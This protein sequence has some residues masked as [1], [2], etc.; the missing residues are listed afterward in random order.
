MYIENYTSDEFKLNLSK[1]NIVIIPVGSLEAHGH[2]LPLGTDIFSPKLFCK[3]INEKLEDSI[4]IAPEI[5]YGQSYELTVYPGTINVPSET[6]SDYMYWVG[7]GF[8][9]NGI[10]KII[11]LNGHG[12]NINALNLASE[13]LI[14]LGA[15]VATINW[16]L[17][18]SSDILTITDTQGHGGE[19][20]TSA[21]LY[22]NEKL[23]HMDKAMKNN[24]KPLIKI[25]YK[26]SAKYLYKDALSG[27]ATKASKEKG[28]KIFKL[29]T[30]KIIDFIKIVD[31]GVYFISEDN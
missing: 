17:D 2:H 19:D 15:E 10:L 16:W 8:Y 1:S 23:V 25:K 29:L 21:I 6:L 30:D 27:D 13:K 22:Y 4:W 18:F 11:F 24:I 26:N 12:G 20:E 9:D 7:K 31:S 14:K 28:G 3:M 5:P